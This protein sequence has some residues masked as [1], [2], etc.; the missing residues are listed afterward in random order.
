MIYQKGVK[1]TLDVSNSYVIT[2][3]DFRVRQ[4]LTNLLDKTFKF[5]KGG[6]V[7]WGFY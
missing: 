7:N 1:L 6:L 2:D 3:D 5:T 4:A